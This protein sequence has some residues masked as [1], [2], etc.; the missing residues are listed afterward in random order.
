MSGFKFSLLFQYLSLIAIVADKDALQRYLY[1]D[2]KELS[3]IAL[4]KSRY[5]FLNS[6]KRQRFLLEFS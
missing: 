3:L 2:G 1:L 4:V 6:I 5:S